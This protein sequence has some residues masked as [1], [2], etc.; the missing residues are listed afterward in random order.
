MRRQSYKGSWK[1]DRLLVVF[2]AYG[3]KFAKKKL[4]CPSWSASS[5]SAGR[6]P[7]PYAYT[8]PI[9]KALKKFKR[10]LSIAEACGTKR[11]ATVIQYAFA[12]SVEEAA[13]F[14]RLYGDWCEANDRTQGVIW[15]NRDWLDADFVEVWN[16]FLLL[17]NI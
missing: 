9:V 7:Q 14:T 10:D 5:S 3:E 2:E 15:G 16:M 13:L 6:S 12:D 17:L 1:H 8:P 11:A 4:L